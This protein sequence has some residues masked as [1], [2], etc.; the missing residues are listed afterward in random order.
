MCFGN[1]IHLE[2]QRASFMGISGRIYHLPLPEQSSS[3]SS[4]CGRVNGR[5]AGLWALMFQCSVSS[6]LY[7]QA[8]RSEGGLHFMPHPFNIQ[9]VMTHRR[10]FMCCFYFHLVKIQN[11]PSQN[12]EGLL[13][14]LSRMLVRWMIISQCIQSTSVNIYLSSIYFTVE[15]L[16]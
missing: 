16:Y 11:F 13:V 15:L 3:R 6:C 7:T 1:K 5:N 9:S 2:I 12:L 14:F 10:C 4:F 8:I